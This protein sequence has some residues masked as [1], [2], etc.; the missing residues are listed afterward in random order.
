MESNYRDGPTGHK[1][2]YIQSHTHTF[3]LNKL[4]W[5]D[6]NIPADEIWV[7]L[8]GDKGGTS[9]KM[10]FQILNVKNPNAV[11]NTCVF[12]AFQ[13]PDSYFN[14]HIALER[15]EDQVDELQQEQWLAYFEIVYVRV[16]YCVTFL[17]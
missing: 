7:K 15:Y 10:N 13:A 12:L 3:R 8:G 16:V 5:H 4:T 1:K 11:N 6:D 17:N 14:L 9:F 2:N